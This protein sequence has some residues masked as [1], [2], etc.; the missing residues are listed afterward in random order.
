MHIENK[1][2]LTVRQ[3]AV[4]GHTDSLVAVNIF[5]KPRLQIFRDLAN[6]SLQEKKAQES[7]QL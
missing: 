7:L 3:K 1:R 5:K 2:I 6:K 4:R